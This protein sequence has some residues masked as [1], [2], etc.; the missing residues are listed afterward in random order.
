VPV[1]GVLAAPALEAFQRAFGGLL[2]T[3]GGAAV[4]LARAGRSWSVEGYRL[5]QLLWAVAGGAAGAGLGALAATRGSA[6][7]LVAGPVVGAMVG[8]LLRDH[9]LVAEGRRRALRIESELPTVLE[10]LAL[11]LSAGEG[12]HDAIRRVAR[13]GSGA[14]ADLLQR[15]VD[16]TAV[17]VSLPTALDRMGDELRIPSLTRVLAHVVG[18][19]E[20]GSPLAEVLRVQAADARERAR[21]DLLEAAG[22]KEIGMMVPLVF[23][24]LPVTVAFAVWPGLFV[25]QTGL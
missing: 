9:L 14:L 6:A 4:R 16:E 5:R 21:R 13:V 24:I 23:L 10:F 8:P 19:L 25:L 12:V 22:R 7:A 11:S 17:G 1:L 15:V 2:G 3:S 20:R 18:A